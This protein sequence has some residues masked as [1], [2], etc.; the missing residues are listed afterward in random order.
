MAA[1]LHCVEAIR[2]CVVSLSSA[3]APF[4]HHRVFRAVVF[5]VVILDS[6]QRTFDR[7]TMERVEAAVMER[8]PPRDAVGRRNA[9]CERHRDVHRALRRAELPADPLRVAAV[10][11]GDPCTGG[12]GSFCPCGEDEGR[13]V[14]P[15]GFRNT[16]H[17]VLVLMAGI[18]FLAKA[19]FYL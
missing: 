11:Q 2:A 12:T 5:E 16:R 9:L 19:M 17:L 3:A 15:C 4:L 7:A 6:L 8:V 10:G 13:W 18:V 14:D 1:R